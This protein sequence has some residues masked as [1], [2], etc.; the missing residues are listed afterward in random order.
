M[1]WL[2][3]EHMFTMYRE[4]K[5]VCVVIYIWAMN[6]VIIIACT[7]VKYGNFSVGFSMHVSVTHD[8]PPP[9][10]SMPNPSFIC[11]HLILISFLFLSFS[12]GVLF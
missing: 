4:I 1:W 3:V 9:S 11:P 7:M 8:D 6:A 5:V 10:I 2:L 12:F